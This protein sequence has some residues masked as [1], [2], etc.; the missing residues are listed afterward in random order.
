MGK[1][2]PEL[3]ALRA[4]G[5]R[6]L[7][8][9][10]K[11]INWLLM[12][13]V[14][15]GHALIEDLPGM[16]KTTLVHFLSHALG[17]ELKRVQFT[18]DLLPADILGSPIYRPQTQDFAFRPGPVFTEVLLAD[19]LNR[20]PP[21]TQSALLQAMEE[22]EVSV[23][24][25]TYHLSENFTV[26][27]TQNP[28]GMAGTYPLPESQLDRFLIKF[29]LGWPQLEAQR[30]LLNGEDRRTQI[31]QLNALVPAGGLA[32]WRK[33]AQDVTVSETL[34]DYV[35]RLVQRSRHGTQLKGLSPR[36]SIELVRAL[37]AWAYLCER[38]HVLP[39]DVR[40]IFPL[41]AGHRLGPALGEVL[42][43]HERARQIFED[44]A[45][46]E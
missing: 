32:R 11:E 19:E 22:R 44:V 31:K 42:A 24:G 33:E 20:A 4:E 23:D 36:A 15:Q 45:V 3:Q 16:G 25:S 9:M 18:S 10:E 35:L 26:V 17:L 28:Q 38:T 12:C 6:L 14:A 21:K 1:G 43:E 30:L 7:P 34:L 46:Y 13:L 39:E 29:S 2:S 5:R 37:K 8:G 40:E 27:A 41:V